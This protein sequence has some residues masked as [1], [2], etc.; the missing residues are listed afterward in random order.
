[1]NWT[2]RICSIVHFVDLTNLFGRFNKKHCSQIK[3]KAT[4]HVTKEGGLAPGP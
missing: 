2:M 3:S 4:G 1:M